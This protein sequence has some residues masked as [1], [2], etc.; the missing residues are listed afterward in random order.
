MIAHDG[1]FSSLAAVRDTADVAYTTVAS[2]TPLDI[3]P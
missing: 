2:K 3:W 1:S